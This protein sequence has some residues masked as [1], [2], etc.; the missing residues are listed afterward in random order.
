ML[1]GG[2]WSMV[3]RNRDCVGSMEQNIAMGGVRLDVNSM[4]FEIT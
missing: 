3:G 4:E 2:F 1:R